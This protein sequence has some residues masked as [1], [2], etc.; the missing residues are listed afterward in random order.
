MLIWSVAV[1]GLVI[2]GFGTGITV[3]ASVAVP[4]PPPLLALRMTLNEPVAI[5]VPE[6][7]PVAELTARPP[8]RLVAPKL[9]GLLVAVIW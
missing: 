9:V 2:V 4:V 8:G 3:S 5:G 6:I 1:V 7:R